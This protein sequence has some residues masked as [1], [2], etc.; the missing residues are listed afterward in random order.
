MRLN[1]LSTTEVSVFINV[2]L[3]AKQLNSFKLYHRDG[4]GYL[5]LKLHTLF[6]SNT[7]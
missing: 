3:L 1:P 5:I 4:D 2:H 6:R 7:D